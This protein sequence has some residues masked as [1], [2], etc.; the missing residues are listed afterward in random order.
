MADSVQGDLLPGAHDV[1][2]EQDTHERSDAGDDR[3]QLDDDF[4]NH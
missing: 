2:A 4:N 3:D 1:H